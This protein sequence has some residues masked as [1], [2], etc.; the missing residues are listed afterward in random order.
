[1]QEENISPLQHNMR[2]LVDL[3]RR[4][5]YCDITFR[6]REPLIGVRLSPRLNAA[7]M[8]GAGAEKMAQLFDHVETR[9]GTVFRAVDVWVIVEFP[10]GLPSDKELAEVDLADGEAE[11][12]PGVSMRQ[13]AKEIYH[14]ADDVQAERMLRRVLAA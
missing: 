7:L 11:V 3:S 9:S 1:M 6:N 14:C 12:V 10:D 2:R 4:E 5:G 8:Y 13:M